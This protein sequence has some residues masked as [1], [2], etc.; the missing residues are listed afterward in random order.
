MT[1]EYMFCF[2]YSKQCIQTISSR[3]KCGFL[4]SV[5]MKIILNNTTPAF[6]KVGGVTEPL[7]YC[8]W[9]KNFSWYHVNHHKI[10]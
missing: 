8:R 10:D 2:M 5:F 1:I 3:R 9:H 4:S 6:Q 7:I